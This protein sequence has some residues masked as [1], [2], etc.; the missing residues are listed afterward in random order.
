[1]AGI[2]KPF[3]STG[4]NKVIPV[5]AENEISLKDCDSPGRSRVDSG[6]TELEPFGN[7][8]NC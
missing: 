2:R 6:G 5:D 4:I 7:S 1:M 8:R 3:I